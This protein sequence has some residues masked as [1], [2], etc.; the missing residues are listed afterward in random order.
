MTNDSFEDSKIILAISNYLQQSLKNIDR[1]FNDL[2]QS[3]VIAHPNKHQ[4]NIS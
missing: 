2:E 3:F 4:I 1:T